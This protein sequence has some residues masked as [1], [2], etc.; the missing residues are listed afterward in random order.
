MTYNSILLAAIES[1]VQAYEAGQM[2]LIT[3]SD[4]KGYIFCHCLQ[5]MAG[6]ISTA[7]IIHLDK[8]LPGLADE[9]SLVLGAEEVVAEI[10]LEPD[11]AGLSPEDKP[12]LFSEDIEADFQRLRAFAE[13]GI[14]HTY[15]IILDEDGCHVRRFPSVP[16]RRIGGSQRSAHL[17]VRHYG[18]VEDPQ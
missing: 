10:R 8:R 3:Q 1:F 13:Q 2:T 7:S 5:A 12:T 11:Y 17:L 9:V 16:W 15:A 18:P 4:M 6:S 14:P